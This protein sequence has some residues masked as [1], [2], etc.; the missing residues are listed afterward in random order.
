MI[1]PHIRWRFIY[2]NYSGDF[3][4]IISA[5][6]MQWIDIHDF[7]K[8]ITIK[9]HPTI[10]RIVILVRIVDGIC[11][12]IGNMILLLEINDA[13]MK[14]WFHLFDFLPTLNVQMYP[15]IT[16]MS[17]CIVTSFTLISFFLCCV[18][19]MSLQIACLSRC[20]VALV[21]LVWLF[22]SM[23]LQMIPQIGCFCCCKITLSALVWLNS[24]VCYQMPLQMAC[25]SRGK[26]A[27]V[28]IV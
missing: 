4:S 19:Q 1:A 28:A 2:V 17:W 25:L 5:E 20:I 3:T 21:A 12:C 24:S 23:N 27:L 9:N 14:H 8:P 6:W 13:I 11:T 7:S 22:P 15:Q 18:F 16:C 10:D 26:V